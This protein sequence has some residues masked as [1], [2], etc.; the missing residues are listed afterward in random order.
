[1][2]NATRLWSDT[3]RNL[4]K[5]RVQRGKRKFM[6]TLVREV[7][8]AANKNHFRI[9]YRFIKEHADSCTHVDKRLKRGEGTFHHGSHSCNS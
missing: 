3:V 2:V 8:A 7:E 1:M 6:I 9:V 5:L 4:D